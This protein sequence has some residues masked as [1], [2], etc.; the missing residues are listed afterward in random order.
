[1][2]FKGRDI[3]SIGDIT[4]DELTYLVTTG[5]EWLKR[6]NEGTLIRGQLQGK[7]LALA[8]FEPSSRT[9]QSFMHAAHLQGMSTLGMLKPD[10]TSVDKFE[11]IHHTIE[12]WRQMEAHALAIRH[13]WEGVA[14]YAADLKQHGGEELSPWVVFNAGDGRHEHPTQSLLDLLTIKE[15]TGRLHDLHVGIGGDLKNGR[16]AHSLLAALRKFPGN[17]FTLVS[18]PE[19][20]LPSVY[21]GDDCQILPLEEAVRQDDLDIY[22]QTRIQ[23]ERIETE[24]EKRRVLGSV[25]VRAELFDKDADFPKVLHPLPINANYPEIER[26]FYRERP[27]LARYFSQMRRGLIMRELLLCATLGVIGEDFDGDGF[28]PKEYSRDPKL[29]PLS[30]GQTSAKKGVLHEITNGMVIDHVPAQDGRSLYDHLTHETLEEE[31][32]ATVAS[33]RQEGKKALMKFPNRLPSDRDHYLIGIICPE[34]TVSIIDDGRVVKKYCVEIPG[35]IEGILECENES[36]ISTNPQEDAPSIFYKRKDS[37]DCHYCD[38]AHDKK[39][40][41]VGNGR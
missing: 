17:R 8:I 39:K 18:P 41:T 25:Q 31:F 40:V 32:F 5:E 14:R 27:N 9:S 12:T 4:K 26:S 20:A 13:T 28:T 35:R 36:C 6:A 38:T 21:M 2:H 7:T 37:L 1:M 29:V 22:Y 15:L 23:L 34:A 10:G 33:S 19:L 16:T 24:G 11:S 30:V 3:V